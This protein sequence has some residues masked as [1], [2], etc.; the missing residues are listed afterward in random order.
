MHVTKATGDPG[1]ARFNVGDPVVAIAQLGSWR[2][3][4]RAGTPGTIAARTR[5]GRFV[6][7]FIP[8]QTLTV[9]PNQIRHLDPTG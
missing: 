3:R 7:D 6:V 1:A 4:V 5:E 8:D 9:H 2:H